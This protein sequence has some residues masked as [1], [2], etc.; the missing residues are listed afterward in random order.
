MG[1]L[2]FDRLTPSDLEAALRLSTQAGWNQLAVDW[3]RLLDFSPEG[4]LAGRL[5]GRLVATATVASYGTDAH[6]IGMVLVDEAVRGRGFGSAILRE[7]VRTARARGSDAIGLDATDLGRPVYLKEGLV[8]SL[9]ID[10]WG[11]S[12]RVPSA[13]P[14]LEVLGHATLDA[15]LALDRTACGADRSALLVHLAMER[16]VLGWVA[17]DEQGAAGYS[18]LR[19]GREHAHLGPVVAVEPGQFQTLLEGAATVLEGAPVVID[20]PRTDEHAAILTS[21]G[22][23][24]RRK[25]T[26]MTFARPVPLLLSPSIRAATS[27][28]LG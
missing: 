16:D 24:V 25:L 11:G 2:S 8:D 9:P 23:E 28:E 10:R 6:W 13:E 1:A 22:L 15:V 26:R 27:F 4:C 5:D 19:P 3:Q 20:V 14:P 17:T 7:A 18:I 12:M 21:F